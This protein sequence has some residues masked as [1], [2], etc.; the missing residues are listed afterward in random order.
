[1]DYL[2]FLVHE[3]TVTFMPIKQL[4]QVVNPVLLDLQQLD[5]LAAVSWAL[6]MASMLALGLHT[7]AEVVKYLAMR[8]ATVLV[9]LL[10][11][12]RELQKYTNPNNHD[13]PYSTL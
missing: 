11:P 13:S 12:N 5:R 4:K 9:P 8:P 6:A 1:M 10:L 7:F 3:T 2:S